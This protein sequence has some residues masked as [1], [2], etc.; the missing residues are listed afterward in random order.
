MS[1]PRISDSPPMYKRPPLV[2]FNGGGSPPPNPVMNAP[3]AFRPNVAA[4]IHR[5]VVLPIK[6]VANALDVAAPL[7]NPLNKSP[8]PSG[9]I[10]GLLTV[11]YVTGRVMVLETSPFSALGPGDAAELNLVNTA[12]KAS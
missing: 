10:I 12:W 9:G 11:L 6:N 3:D 5:M 8:F 1:N 7:K 2:F 4:L